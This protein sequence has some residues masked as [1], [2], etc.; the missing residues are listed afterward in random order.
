[1]SFIMLL[2]L[3]ESFIEKEDIEVVF[4]I[5][6]FIVAERHIGHRVRRNNNIETAVI[7]TVSRIVFSNKILVPCHWC[8]KSICFES[9]L[10]R[11]FIIRQVFKVMLSAYWQVPLPGYDL[12]LFIL[13]I[14]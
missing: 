9:I 13:N 6:T 3:N 10:L 7:A 12:L 11:Y 4:H 2:A 1:M 5:I 8:S 14:P